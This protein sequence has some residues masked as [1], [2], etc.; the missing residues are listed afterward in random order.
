MMLEVEERWTHIIHQVMYIV[1]LVSLKESEE[2][3]V[4]TMVGSG[5]EVI[6]YH[7]SDKTTAR[8]NFA[9]AIRHFSYTTR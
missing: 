8:S 7:G 5:P 9:Y 6:L 1:D 4:R 3:L 2:Y